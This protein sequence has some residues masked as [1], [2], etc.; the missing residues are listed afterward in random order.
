[1]VYF[2][3]LRVEIRADR[4]SLEEYESATCVRKSS[5]RSI[6]RMLRLPSNIPFSIYLH[7]DHC[8]FKWRHTANGLKV[9]V[10]FDDGQEVKDIELYFVRAHVRSDM[11]ASRLVNTLNGDE[12]IHISRVPRPG[13]NSWDVEEASFRTVSVETH[14]EGRRDLRGEGIIRVAVERCKLTPS[15]RERASVSTPEKASVN[16]AST[17]VL[18]GAGIHSQVELIDRVSRVMVPLNFR[19]VSTADGLAGIFSFHYRVPEEYDILKCIDQASHDIQDAGEGRRRI[20]ERSPEPTMPM[21][22]DHRSPIRSRI[23]S[24]QPASCSDCVGSTEV[25]VAEIIEVAI[26]PTTSL[27]GDGHSSTQTESTT[28]EN[29]DKADEITTVDQDMEIDAELE[30]LSAPV[31]NEELEALLGRKQEV[32]EDLSKLQARRDAAYV[33][34]I[35]G[36]KEKNEQKTALQRN[37]EQLRQGLDESTSIVT[38]LQNKHKDL[39]AKHMEARNLQDQWEEKTEKARRLMEQLRA[40]TEGLEAKLRAQDEILKRIKETLGQ[41]QIEVMDADATLTQ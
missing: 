3:G 20:I 30:A 27:T 1:M 17:E 14:Y 13:N 31:T 37:T 15:T 5:G 7:V 4:S 26:E 33:A 25:E 28:S 23:T 22:L 34:L 36:I 9:R 41:D 8:K 32:V 12:Y 11:N 39:K 29:D 2:D 35:N 19:S 40:Q 21:D 16:K 38:Q 24:S 10:D 6:H 18:R